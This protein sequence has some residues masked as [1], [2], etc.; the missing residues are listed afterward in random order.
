VT[1][2]NRHVLSYGTYYT[3]LR[4]N[5][6][7]RSTWLL[8]ALIW[9]LGGCVSSPLYP[10]TLH[11]AECPLPVPE[12]LEEGHTITCGYL[13][14]P[15]DRALPNG[16]QVKLP[17]A[18]I[19]AESAHPHPDPLVYIVGG[20]G[21]SALAEFNQIYSWFRT[22]RRD[23]DLIFYDQRGTLLADPVLECTLNG[24]PPTAAEIEQV[25][26]RVPAYLHPLDAND[27]TIARCA[28]ELQAQGIDL[29]HYDTATHARDLLDLLAALGYN[30]Y[31]LYGTSY[32]T[33]IALEVMRIASP[34][35]RAVVLDS[36]YPPTVN[37]YEMQNSFAT[38][39]VLRGSFAQCT[40]QPTCA[41]AYPA[42]AERFDRIVV[43]L[44]AQPL[45]LPLSWQPTFSGD[46]L[47]ALM[48]TRLDRD[49]LAYVPRLV[50]EVERGEGTTLVALLRGEVPAPA[51]PR[52]TLVSG[53]DEARVTEFVL[54]LNGAFLS[55]Q[56]E[57]NGEAMR[58]WQQLT[59]RN[60]DRSRLSDFI[61]SY[62]LATSAKPLLAQ[63]AELT[64]ADL[65]LVFAELR[66]VPIH[67]LTRGANL[68]VECRDEQPFNDYET[69]ITAHRALGIPDALVAAEVARLRHYWAQCALFPT[70]IAANSQ[71]Q[72]VTSSIPV[73]IFQGGL[74]TITPPSWAAQAQRTLS[75]AT[76]LEFPGQGHVVIQQPI[77]I[78]SGCPAQL[79]RQ[80]LDDPT[81]AP[82]ATCITTN[83]QIPWVL[84]EV[85]LP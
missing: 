77:S 54:A 31:N 50:D 79:A 62:L 58:E 28:D 56:L 85:S 61:E 16:L 47:L 8:L 46:D 84:P 9:L 69:V 57:L 72:P 24:A 22:L 67:P 83:Y 1:T 27:A 37:A 40:A 70:G 6:W 82:V 81:Q 78:A 68:A 23:R 19:R 64:E 52:P 38:L 75:N 42:L 2:P 30:E 48:L 63:L 29:A 41:A 10:R 45:D 44:N 3:W 12:E 20:P 26:A 5:S 39:E 35:V 76:Y 60:A 25:S 32:G 4:Q 73:L 13:Q 51:P 55:Q 18:R 11:S 21:G 65:A 66:A 80:F 17:Y 15:Q 43:Q 7:Q 74:D 34:G 33:R 71:T 36:I 53:A 14:V 59:A 49:L